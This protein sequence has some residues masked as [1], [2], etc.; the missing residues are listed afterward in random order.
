M[1]A[2]ER[3]TRITASIAYMRSR[4][5]FNSSA[6]SSRHDTKYVDDVLTDDDSVF[7]AGA[8]GYRKGLITHQC[9]SSLR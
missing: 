8:S 6:S 7:Q 9:G 2:T 1:E 3:R 4:P 5:A